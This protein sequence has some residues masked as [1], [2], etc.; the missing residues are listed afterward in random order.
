MPLNEG[1]SAG[2]NQIG[3][4]ERCAGHQHLETLQANH[5]IRRITISQRSTSM[6]FSFRFLNPHFPA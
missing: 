4:G 2:F 5:T 6:W 1:S 3:L